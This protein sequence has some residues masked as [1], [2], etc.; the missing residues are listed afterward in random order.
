MDQ[1]HVHKTTHGEVAY[2]EAG[3]MS[4]AGVPA[5]RFFEATNLMASSGLVLYLFATRSTRAGDAVAYLHTRAMARGTWLSAKQALRLTLRTPH[6]AHSRHGRA[7]VA[8]TRGH[9]APP[10]GPAG[11]GTLDVLHHKTQSIFEAPR[12]CH[13][14]RRHC[15]SAIIYRGD[16]S[17]GASR[18]FL[19]ISQPSVCRRM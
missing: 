18:V 9:R 15:G 11:F 10:A 13:S 17:P 5:A 8:S 4:S 2:P 16:A 12:P 6:C 19:S 7:T 14:R 3:K 1:L